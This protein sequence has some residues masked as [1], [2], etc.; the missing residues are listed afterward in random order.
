MGAVDMITNL[1]K[2]EKLK[3]KAYKKE[4]RSEFLPGA[5]EVMFNPESYSQTYENV[6]TKYQGINTSGR[7]AKYSL[8]QPSK[9]SF[10]FIIDGTGVSNIGLT[11]I[12][13]LKKTVTEEVK[14]FLEMTT[15]LDGEIHEP[16]FL[17]ISWGNLTF[18]C[19]LKSLN[20]NYTLFD[21]F[22]VPLRAELNTTFIS[23]ISDK[24][25]NQLDQKES[26]DLTHWRVF[27]AH[28]TLPLMCE[29]IYGSPDHFIRVAQANKLDDFRNIKP[30]QELFFPPIEY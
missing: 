27:Q 2:L 14:K 29:K 6:F 16:R 30:G 7:S 26:P 1:F 19:R 23:D 20:I 9:I 4:T 5:Y 3:I 22:G 18:D 24:K 13:G 10:K 11:N 25:R 28:D 17:V 8:S 15:E 21:N 12:R